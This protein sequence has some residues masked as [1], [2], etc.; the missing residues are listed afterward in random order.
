VRS[1]GPAGSSTIMLTAVA[2]PSSA[3][4]IVTTPSFGIKF[5][6]TIGGS[7]RKS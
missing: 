7:A 2:R 4:A 1:V 5:A 6:R 3:N